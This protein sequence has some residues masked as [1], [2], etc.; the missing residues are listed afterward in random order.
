[1]EET[2]IVLTEEELQEVNE[3]RSQA[4]EIFSRLGQLTIQRNNQLKQI[5]K[6][7]RE[8][9]ETHSKLI[10]RERKVVKALNEKYGEGQLNPQTGEFTSTPQAE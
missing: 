1:M 3:I 7:E 10:E 4:Q 2:K 6:V 9:L 8:L 5:E